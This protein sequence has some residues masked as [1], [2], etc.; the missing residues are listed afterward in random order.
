MVHF[1][2]LLGFS[3][4]AQQVTNDLQ[5]FF[6]IARCIVE[7]VGRRDFGIAL[8]NA[9]LR[10]VGRMQNDEI[11]IVRHERFRRRQS[12]GEIEGWHPA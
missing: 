2:G 12:A 9:V 10:I 8:I 1:D 5:R 6:H 11:R 7:H 3:R 4:L